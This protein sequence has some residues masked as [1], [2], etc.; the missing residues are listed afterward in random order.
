MNSHYP[1]QLSQQNNFS[2]D[3]RLRDALIGET[4]NG[5]QYMRIFIE[6]MDTCLPAYIWKEELYRGVYL[7]NNVLAKIE[8]RS[9]YYYNQLQVDLTAINPVGFKRAGEVIRLIPQS[10]CP[11]PELLVDLQSAIERI[12][13]PALRQFIEAVFADDG[14][15]FAFVSAPASIKHHHNHPGGL[16]KHSLECMGMVSRHREFSQDSYQ[17]GQVAALLHDVGKI[18][19]MTHSMARTSLGHSAEHEKLTYEVLKPYLSQLERSWPEGAKE[20]KYDMGWKIW[21]SV[22]RYNMADLVACSDRLSAGFDM[23]RKR[24]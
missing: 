4:K 8:G 22:P 13:I 5:K 10:I 18:L 6:D 1:M 21:R 12:T 3:F 14:I 9:R 11:L 17:L 20:L 2:G 7:P 19:T 15:A 23:D 24:A 16:L